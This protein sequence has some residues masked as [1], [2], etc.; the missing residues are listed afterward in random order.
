MSEAEF[1]FDL[2][3]DASLLRKLTRAELQS[4]FDDLIDGDALDRH[5]SK[6]L[7]EEIKLFWENV[8]LHLYGPTALVYHDL[9]H[10]YLKPKK[11]D[12]FHAFVR[13]LKI[14]DQ[15]DLAST[16]SVLLKCLEAVRSVM[17]EAPPST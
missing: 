9:D 15:R 1:V 11:F 2:D 12:T 10:D 13:G 7:K 3:G 17:K 6:R 8:E 4:L 5:F 16:E 14:L